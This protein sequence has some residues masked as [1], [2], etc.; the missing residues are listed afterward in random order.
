MQVDG[1]VDL[2]SSEDLKCLQHQSRKLRSKSEGGEKP[3]TQLIQE[4]SN[5]RLANSM[6]VGHPQMQMHQRKGVQQ[7]NLMQPPV[8]AKQ[9]PHS[10]QQ[11]YLKQPPSSPV[12]AELK[13]IQLKLENNENEIK[14]VEGFLKG[15]IRETSRNR[16]L[17]EGAVLCAQREMLEMEWSLAIKQCD[18]YVQEILKTQQ[19]VKIEEIK[20]EE[21]LLEET[22]VR[23]GSEDIL[24]AE[25]K[26]LRAQNEMLTIEGVLVGK[27]FNEYVRTLLCTQ[28]EKKETEVKILDIHAKELEIIEIDEVLEKAHLIDT[29]RSTFEIKSLALKWHVKKYELFE[30]EDALKTTSLSQ[31][32]TESLPLEAD[33]LRKEI[34]IVRINHHFKTQKDHSDEGAPLKLELGQ[35]EKDIGFL[36]KRKQYVQI[37]Y[38]LRDMQLKKS[39]RIKLETNFAFLQVKLLMSKKSGGESTD[40]KNILDHHERAY[41]R[42]QTIE[43]YFLED[44]NQRIFAASLANSARNRA[45]IFPLHNCTK[46]NLSIQYRELFIQIRRNTIHRFLDREKMINELECVMK[47]R[48]HTLHESLPL[49]EEQQCLF[50]INELT[51]F[52]SLKQ[53]LEREQ[54]STEAILSMKKECWGAKERYPNGYDEDTTRS[55]YDYGLYESSL[56]KDDDQRCLLGMKYLELSGLD[57]IN[58][59][60]LETGGPCLT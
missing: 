50:G 10:P 52:E 23:A 20:K 6:N 51:D 59:E 60:L 34:R 15:S 31:R 19:T 13:Q 41:E 40:L 33:I 24:K 37:K 28:Y 48:N 9:L 47:T 35:L 26:V 45:G 16:L 39:E 44:Q 32:E 14:K 30:I 29:E 58:V 4:K 43:G 46:Y 55:I 38:Q 2:F 1:W 18:A 36:A 12:Q 5:V 42:M 21:E 8:Y 25:N 27:K 57:P 54:I 11:Q 56:L 7:L 53:F 22:R 17:A 49:N 3:S